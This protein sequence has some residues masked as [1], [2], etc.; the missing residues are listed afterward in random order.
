MP[1][2]NRKRG[3]YLEYQTRDALA[4]YGWQITRAG[5]SLGAADL[6]ALRAG[7]TPL[8]IQCKILGPGRK[9]PR[10]DPDERAALFRA[11][12][13]S[14][15]R[16]IIAT[17]YRRGFVTLLELPGPHFTAYPLVDELHVPSRPGKGAHNDELAA[18]V[19]DVPVPHVWG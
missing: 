13:L 4:H 9:T 3:D 11:A 7:K 6:I 10:I 2:S 16:P 14:G 17:R 5:G 8:L 18:G 12:A 15:G 1:N 19:P